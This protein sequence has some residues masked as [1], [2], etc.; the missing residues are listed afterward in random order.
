MINQSLV[1]AQSFNDEQLTLIRSTVAKGT[2]PEEFNLFV[3]V[4]K[5][6]QLN[7]F[8]RQIYAVTRTSRDGSRNLTIQVSIDGFRLLAERSGQYGGQVGPEWCGEDGVWKDVW[9]SDAPPAAARV[10]VIRKDCE[11]PV[12]GVARFK[13][14]VQPSSPLWTKMPEVLLSKCAEALALRKAFPSETSGVYVAEEMAQADERQPLPTVSVQPVQPAQDEP[15]AVEVPG[16]VVDVAPPT[17]PAK[18]AI[19]LVQKDK[20][21]TKPLAQPHVDETVRQKLN[22]LM[23]LGQFAKRSEF[24]RYA[25]K[26]L[27]RPVAAEQL[28]SLDEGELLQIECSLRS[29]VP[30][31]EEQ[32]AS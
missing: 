27:D 21:T 3:E 17:P 32:Q 15:A 16:E 24:A 7:P 22:S 8:A 4:C 5:L 6:R 23:Q 10:G 28:L 31:S 13:S 11:K 12:W 1:K 20:A 9:L 14:Y 18:P 19:N 30:P 26:A 29:E 2:T 25:S